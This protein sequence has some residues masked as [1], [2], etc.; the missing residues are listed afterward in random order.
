VP[1]AAGFVG[2]IAVFKAAIAEG[3]LAL[4]MA[5]VA[6]VFLGGALSFL[7]AFQ[8]Y[9]RRFMKPA[10]GDAGKPSPLAA[11][12]LLVALAALVVLLGLWPEPLVY[13]SEQSA[14]VLT[15][16]SG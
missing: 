1:P 16:G 11:R 14:A 4:S 13:L 9:Q 10:P 12:V 5:L 6:L 7:Y 15:G 8:V 2:K 3:S